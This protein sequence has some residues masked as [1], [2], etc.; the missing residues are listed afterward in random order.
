MVMAV[1]QTSSFPCKR[2]QL[3]SGPF[4]I[5]YDYLYRYITI[6]PYSIIQ[7]Q[8]SVFPG[9]NIGLRVVALDELGVATSALFTLSHSSFDKSSSFDEVN[10]FSCQ[11]IINVFFLW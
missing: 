6:I 4:K 2:L 7:L 5:M 11:M 3:N 8:I 9:E 10:T 1:P